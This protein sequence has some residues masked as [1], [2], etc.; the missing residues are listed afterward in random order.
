MDSLQSLFMGPFG[1]SFRVFKEYGLLPKEMNFIEFSENQY[2]DY[3]KVMGMPSGRLFVFIP[4][5]FTGKERD[6]IDTLA[7][8]Y[9]LEHIKELPTVTDFEKREMLEA[10][11]YVYKITENLSHDDATDIERL[12][13][14]LNFLPMFK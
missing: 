5:D 6:E 3:C 2:A 12:D 10:V 13:K 8:Q 14:F 11:E 1:K 9:V 4:L 7:N